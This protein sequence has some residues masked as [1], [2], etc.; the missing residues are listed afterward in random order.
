VSKL[1][2]P[3]ASTTQRGRDS[4]QTISA[5]G[6]LQLGNLPGGAHV[7]P[8]QLDTAALATVG[9]TGWDRLG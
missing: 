5:A 8:M 6:A 2:S 7:S 3:V 9:P 4:R 1:N